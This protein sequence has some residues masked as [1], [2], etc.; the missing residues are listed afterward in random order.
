MVWSCTTAEQAPGTRGRH[1]VK[2]KT[3]L[4]HIK[5]LDDNERNRQL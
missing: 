5:V 1:L 2:V 4:L 3:A